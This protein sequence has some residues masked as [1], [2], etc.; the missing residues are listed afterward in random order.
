[1]G[2]G[3]PAHRCETRTRK[4]RDTWID[5]AAAPLLAL[6]HSLAASAQASQTPPQFS[7][8]ASRYH[9]RSDL[10]GLQPPPERV[11]ASG[12]VLR[13]HFI[14]QVPCRWRELL[15]RRS[16]HGRR[17][18]E[19]VQGLRWVGRV[20]RVV[21]ARTGVGKHQQPWLLMQCLSTPDPFTPSPTPQSHW[22]PP[23]LGPSCSGS[24]CPRKTWPASPS[25]P[26]AP[27]W[28]PGTPRCTTG[29]GRCQQR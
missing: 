15:A 1:M 18:P 16:G 23:R 26:T 20:G 7:V 11:V 6:L 25:P 3:Q 12:Q 8:A 27:T 29:E 9:A 5:H 13:A 24:R 17:A 4:H 21:Y 10:R 2:T 22:C 19:A 14:P 28:L